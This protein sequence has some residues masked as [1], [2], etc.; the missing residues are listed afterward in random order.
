MARQLIKGFT[1]LMVVATL[2]FVTSVAS[3]YGQSSHRQVAQIPFEFSVGEKSMPAGEYSV[4]TITGDGKVLNISNTQQKTSAVRMTSPMQQIEPASTGKLVFRRYGSQ[5][6]LTEVWQAGESTA[7]GLTKSKQQ[8]AIER[9]LAAI[10]AR[11][12]VAQ[13]NY[14]TIEIAAVVR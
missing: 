4:G 12:N 5:Y 1:M 3:T 6:F 11:S 7:R 9:E 2:A 8:R 13:N 14:E 10:P